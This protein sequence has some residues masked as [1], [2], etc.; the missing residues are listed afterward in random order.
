MGDRVD[1]STSL[2][3]YFWDLSSLKEEKRLEASF[4]LISHLES[5]KEGDGPFDEELSYCIQRLIGGLASHR[6]GARQGYFVVFCEILAK[7]AEDVS[8][9]CV[10]KLIHSKLECIGNAKASEERGSYFGRIFALLALVQSGLLSSQPEY[11]KIAIEKLMIVYEKKYNLREFCG[12][13]LTKLI[14]NISCELEGTEIFKSLKLTCGWNE[15]TPEK[16]M[17]LLA[18]RSLYKEEAWFKTYLGSHWDTSDIVCSENFDKISPIMLSTSQTHP[19]IHSLWPYL[20]DNLRHNQSWPLFWST[21][22]DKSLLISTHERKFLLHQLIEKLILPSID[23]SEVGV[24]FSVPFLEQVYTNTRVPQHP[25]YSTS[26]HLLEVVYQCTLESPG[27]CVG[28]WLQLKRCKKQLKEF[29]SKVQS[30]LTVEG[31]AEYVHHMMTNNQ[32]QLTMQILTMLMKLPGDVRSKEWLLPLAHHTFI[33]A[34]LSPQDEDCLVLND[35]QR[36]DYHQKFMTIAAE[37]AN[38]KLDHGEV[39]SVSMVLYVKSLLK[40]NKSI[41]N[42]KFTKEEKKVWSDTINV[43]TELNEKDDKKDIDVALMHLMGLAALEIIYDRHSGISTCQELMESHETVKKEFTK[44]GKKKCKWMEVLMDL[45]LGLLSRPHQVW[46]WTIEKSFQLL[47]DH[48][49]WESI[50]L[51]L[52]VV[53]PQPIEEIMEVEERDEEGNDDEGKMEGEEKVFHDPTAEFM[54]DIRNALGDMA[55]VDSDQESVMSLGDNEMEMIDQA[56]IDVFKKRQTL[57]E[58][59]RQMKTDATTMMH[60]RMKVL[61]LI[62]KYIRHNAKSPLRPLVI[63]LLQPLYELTVRYQTHKTLSPL[64]AKAASLLEKICK[65]KICGPLESLD[66]GLLHSILQEHL[67]VNLYR[68]K[69]LTVPLITL[70]TMFVIKLLRASTVPQMETRANSRKR[71]SIAANDGDSKEKTNRHGALD[72]CQLNHWCS[73]AVSHMIS[74]KNSNVPIGFFQ[75]YTERHPQ[76]ALKLLPAI[77]DALSKPGSHYKLVQGYNLVKLILHHLIKLDDKVIQEDLYH[78]VQPLVDVCVGDMLS[79]QLAKL[80]PVLECLESL[81]ITCKSH[82]QLIEA[83]DESKLMDILSA[84]PPSKLSDKISS[85]LGSLIDNK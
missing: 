22:I 35:E 30:K 25:L 74:T 19:R 39:W 33:S 85:F 15:C 63:N 36:C 71:K 75:D 29:I 11:A 44:G 6:K 48:M 66:V 59:K 42:D 72:V 53:R 49:T 37:L 27:L 54:A 18:M 78:V 17:M 68:A 7:F 41:L 57:N 64:S 13:V 50:D 58:S 9:E 81:L 31:V 26:T 62:H 69:K 65:S 46:R 34:N 67:T 24:V 2:L 56:L 32:S 52:N 83:V 84:I 55:A 73:D 40:S 1:E 16:L 45:M 61:D 8:L 76:F 21:V 10:F 12:V 38:L 14:E 3:Q 60:F 4:K 5:S 80:T 43:I 20:V 70:V 51:M 47:A 82:D 79:G 23:I 77:I 28:I